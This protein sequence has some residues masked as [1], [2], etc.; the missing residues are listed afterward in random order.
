MEQIALLS[1]RRV[2]RIVQN[3]PLFIAHYGDRGKSALVGKQNP[4]LLLRES[5]ELRR[6][7]HRG[8]QVLGHHTGW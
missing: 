4:S 3:E 2:A 7:E 6:A 1:L 5:G 8:A